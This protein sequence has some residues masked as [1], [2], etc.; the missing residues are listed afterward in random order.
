MT[1]FTRLA[2]VALT[3][4]ALAA[5]NLI[6]GGN[7][8]SAFD[9]EPGVCFDDVEGTDVESVPTVA[10]DQPHDNEVFA[11][12][13]YPA[14]GDEPYPGDS[15]MQSYADTEC[16]GPFQDYVGLDYDSSV[17]Y[18]FP[19]TPSEGSW[20]QGDRE[21]ICALYEQGEKLTGSARGTRR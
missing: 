19:I 13:N 15:A 9:L 5:C 2:A 11:V 8:T 16:K 6:P 12:L 4:A 14:G 7:Q 1:R 17:F 21:I 10:C 18:V 3:A 20:G